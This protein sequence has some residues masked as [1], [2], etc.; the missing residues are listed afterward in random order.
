MMDRRPNLRL[1]QYAA[2]Y[3]T[4]SVFAAGLLLFDTRAQA[5]PESTDWLVLLLIVL[6]VIYAGE[7]L[8]GGML[9]HALASLQDLQSQPFRLRWWLM[10]YYATMCILFAV[11]AV[12]IFEWVAR[13][14]PYPAAAGTTLLSQ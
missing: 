12:V 3:L 13:V 11:T 10:F 5:P 6:P 14:T 9:Y 1:L 7:W 8:S 2:I 4:I